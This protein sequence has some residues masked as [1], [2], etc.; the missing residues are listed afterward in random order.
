MPRAASVVSSFGKNASRLP[1]AFGCQLCNFVFL[2]I[3]WV[4]RLLS[5]GRES[6]TRM[7]DQLKKEA[8]QQ[9]LTK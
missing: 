6:Q 4:A 5:V 7:I 3:N 2:Q 8:W 1:N 9:N